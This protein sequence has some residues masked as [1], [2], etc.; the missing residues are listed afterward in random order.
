M[1]VEEI[2]H[3]GVLLALIISHSF[4]SDGLSF[5][6]STDMPLQLGYMNHPEGHKIIPHVHNVVERQLSQTQEVLIVRTGRTRLDLYDRDKN[7]VCSRE[8]VAGDII[9]L[10]NG[11]HGLEMMEPTEIVEVKNGPYDDKKDKTRFTEPAVKTNSSEDI[12]LLAK[13]EAGFE[14][15]RASDKPAVPQQTAK[16]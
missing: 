5:F 4:R 2:R 1:S 9:L 15:V 3:N 14:T 6:T 7:F 10:A 12:V 11:G 8:L 13:D 16:K